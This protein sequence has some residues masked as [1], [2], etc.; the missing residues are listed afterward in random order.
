MCQRRH[1]SQ[2]GGP[3]PSFVASPP[4]L[5]LSVCPP[6]LH[7]KTRV[8]ILPSLCIS[9][10]CLQHAGQ[11]FGC[12]VPS[13]SFFYLNPSPSL[14]ALMILRCVSWAPV[15]SS[16][17]CERRCRRFFLVVGGRRS[18]RSTHSFLPYL[19][20]S[21]SS[22]CVWFA[23]HFIGTWTHEAFYRLFGMRHVFWWHVGTLSNACIP[24]DCTAR[25]GPRT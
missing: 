8:H 21:L 17:L 11:C 9:L 10:A 2:K 20:P 5:T 18:S 15:V 25:P 14:D 16:T 19:N 4:L 6:P 7:T 23:V 1:A 24:Q 22:A 3:E 13:R 12:A